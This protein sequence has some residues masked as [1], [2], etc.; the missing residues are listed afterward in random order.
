MIFAIFS[1]S[2]H[3]RRCGE[4]ANQMGRLI[5]VCGSSPQ[6]RGTCILSCSV[7]AF[8]RFIPAGAGNI[9][10]VSEFS[11]PKTVH[12]RRCGEHIIEVSFHLNPFGSSPQVRGTFDCFVYP[13]SKNRFIPAGAG[14]MAYFETNYRPGPVHPRRCGEHPIR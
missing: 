13:N 9:T 10:G 7:R 3:P 8:H 1:P 14:N 12:P 5:W 2:V 6:V 11:L 4:H